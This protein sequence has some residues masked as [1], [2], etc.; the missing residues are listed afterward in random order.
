MISRQQTSLFGEEKSISS[1]EASPAN[2]SQQRAKEKVPGTPDT[3]GRKCSGLY[4]RFAPS[5]SLERMFMDSLIGMEGWFSTRCALTWKMKASKSSRLFCQLAVSTPRTKDIGSGLLLTPTTKEE[6]MDLEKFKKRM[7]KYPNGTTM[8]NLATQVNGLLKTPT[9]MDGEVT[10][11]KKTPTSGN[12][13]TLAQEIMSQYPPTMAKLLPTPTST[14]DVKGGCTR[15][16]PK[17]QNDTLA[18]SI[19]GILGEPGK[20]SQLNPRFVAEMMGFPPDYLE[21]PFQN[22]DRNQSKPT[23]TP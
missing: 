18:H 1:P 14:S 6:V 7:E 17:R 12:S 4:E 2:P 19:H 3:F 20:T 13:G 23:E 16:D 21:L 8:P 10:S 5:G 15:P 9:S 22:T 11:G